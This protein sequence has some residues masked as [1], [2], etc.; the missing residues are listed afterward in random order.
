[1]YAI[2]FQKD[3]PLQTQLYE[4]RSTIEWLLYLHI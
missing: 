4:S 2:E 1:M 3:D